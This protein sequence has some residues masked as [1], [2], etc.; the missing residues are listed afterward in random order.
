MANQI[1]SKRSVQEKLNLLLQPQPNKIRPK[2]D[3]KI[4]RRLLL[5]CKHLQK[6]RQSRAKQCRRRQ[7]LR[8]VHNGVSDQGGVVN[9]EQAPSTAT[10]S[11]IYAESSYTSNPHPFSPESVDH[12]RGLFAAV[13]STVEVVKAPVFSFFKEQNEGCYSSTT[14]I[15]GPQ[16][17]MFS[18]PDST[19]SILSSDWAVQDCISPRERPSTRILAQDD[20][21]SIYD[22]STITDIREDLEFDNIF[23]PDLGFDSD[24]GPRSSHSFQKPFIN[25]SAFGSADVFHP[26]VPGKFPMVNPT[27]M[28]DN[29]DP[30]WGAD[31]DSPNLKEFEVSPLQLDV[32]DSP[33]SPRSQLEYTQPQV[34]PSDENMIPG[35]EH[36]RTSKNS[37]PTSDISILL[38]N[39]SLSLRSS[40][41][42]GRESRTSGIDSTMAGFEVHSPIVL[43]GS[44]PGYCWQQIISKNQLSHC[45]QSHRPQK[46]DYQSCLKNDQACRA[47]DADCLSRIAQ[48]KIQKDDLHE[49]DIFGNTTIHLS[50]SMF[51][52]PSYLISL[53]KLG[54]A[55]NVLNNAGQTF[56]HLLK[57]EVLNHCDDF[58]Y[59]LELLRV[60]G[61]NFRQHD[62]LG[63]SPLH[64]LIRPW[65]DQD[66]L[67]EIITKL[68]SLPISR[69]ISTSR[70]SFGYTVTGQLNLHETE[71]GLEL[72][73]AILSLSCETEHAIFDSR[74]FGMP[75]A[76]NNMPDINA[77]NQ[78]SA[79]NYENHPHIESLDD[80]FLYEQHV[81]Y[82][83]TI[84][85]AKDSPWFQDSNGRNGL[86]CLAEASLV[87]PD[88]PLPAG[89]LSRLDELKDMGDPERDSDRDCFIKCLL[90]V[91]VDPDNYDNNGNTP[92]MA[93]VT[94]RR[95]AEDDGATT[96]ILSSLL[97]AGSDISRRNRQGETALHL[98]VKLGRRA[99]TKFLLASGANIHARTS[100]GLGVLELGQNS[101]AECK[102]DENLYAQIMLCL[103]LAT[104]FG[105]VS[106]PTILDEWASPGWQVVPKESSEPK[107]FKLVKKYIVVQ[108]KG[109]RSGKASRNL[110]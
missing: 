33:S 27:Y 40:S 47:P 67:R 26:L 82:W 29:C 8:A 90:N 74:G 36:L 49:I 108:L 58:C 6:N 1:Y 61:F 63:Q 30:Y 45:D 76:Q 38:S 59:L 5:E 109:R 39:M 65:I 51:A 55:V 105:A 98:A 102:Q 25:P 15:S 23:F 94:H 97:A 91:G 79:R 80:L 24:F 37:P 64:L 78:Q 9:Y 3:T 50:A 12:Q 10:I 68:G 104:S 35:A 7:K 70:D 43:P 85:A 31:F 106:A 100:A 34:S 84:V 17:H 71:S 19:P 99:A 18:L 32:L 41:H 60:H 66:I 69:H 21:N 14:T 93:F 2:G 20:S 22:S 86:H 95:A 96:R 54:A 56:L 88:N 110:K 73:Q 42:D 87:T 53:I 83:R 77:I 75:E 92:F 101:A 103:S 11:S 52:P 57:P 48:R 72:D 46:C 16:T 89:L 28:Q 81:D 13:N 107:G 44:F 62:H 4:L